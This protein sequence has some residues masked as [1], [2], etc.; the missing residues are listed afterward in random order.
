MH[1]CNIKPYICKELQLYNKMK[2]IIKIAFVLAFFATTVA[3]KSTKS[4]ASD[5]GKAE[6][7]PA[8]VETWILANQK[9]A[10][11]NGSTELCYQVKKAGESDYTPMNV[12]IDGFTFEEGNKYQIVVNVAHGKYSLKEVLYKVPSK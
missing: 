7:E 1:L 9:V 6:K 8:K 2:K 11:S 10:C 5:T 12:T 4:A 3:C